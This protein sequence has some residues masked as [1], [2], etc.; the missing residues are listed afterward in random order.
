M[1]KGIVLGIL[2]GMMVT[3]LGCTQYQERT[4]DEGTVVE[5]HTIVE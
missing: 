2:L 1:K 5:Q 3:A 4:I